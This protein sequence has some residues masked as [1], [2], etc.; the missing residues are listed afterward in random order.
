MVENLYKVGGSL[1]RIAQGKQ[2]LWQGKVDET[3]GLFSSLNKKSA[4]NFCTYLR[5]HR[6]R[7]INYDY[8]Q[9]QNICLIAS[10]AVE[11][12]LTVY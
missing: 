11:S 5:N 3:L 12:I 4:Y 10:G 2:L 6:H 1:R 9:S 7:I 8:F